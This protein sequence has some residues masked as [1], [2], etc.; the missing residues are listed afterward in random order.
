M[1]VTKPSWT[2]GASAFLD[3]FLNPVRADE[4]FTASTLLTT[5]VFLPKTQWLAGRVYNT[6]S[7]TGKNFVPALTA[8]IA[9][10]VTQDSRVRDKLSLDALLVGYQ[11]AFWFCVA[12]IT[13]SLDIST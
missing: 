5:S 13:M 9:S 4:I 3:D 7:E 11:A 12:I 10:K 6:V 8:L 1:A 2:Y